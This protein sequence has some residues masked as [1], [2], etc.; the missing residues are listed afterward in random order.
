KLFAQNDWSK[1]NHPNMSSAQTDQART[2][3]SIRSRADH[4]RHTIQTLETLMAWHPLT[5]WPEYLSKFQVVSKQLENIMGSKDDEDSLLPESMHHWVCAP[6]MSLPDPTHI[7]ILLRT[8]EDPEMEKRDEELLQTDTATLL[9]HRKRK[10]EWTWDELEVQK[11]T[12]NATVEGFEDSLKK[13]ADEL[14]K[15]IKVGKFKE[16]V[17]PNSTQGAAF[18]YMES[19]QWT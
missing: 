6:R 10:A 2:L 19:G 5:Q 8:R 9:P 14:L 4:L 11:E 12:F 15:R 17:R 7:P 1:F 13:S 18:R 16:V 3:Q